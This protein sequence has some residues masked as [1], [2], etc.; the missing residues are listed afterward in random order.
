MPLRRATVVAMST[1]SEYIKREPDKKPMEWAATF[2]ISRPYFYD[3]VGGNRYPS[4]AVANRIAAATG[5]EVPVTV[6]PNIAAVL[7]AAREGAA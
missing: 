6:W 2:G 5:G 1:L 7:D 4:I 3:L